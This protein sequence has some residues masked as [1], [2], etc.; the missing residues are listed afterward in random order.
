MKRK[1]K[2]RIAAGGVVFRKTGRRIR[3]ALI[4]RADWTVWCLPK[5]HL[6]PGETLEEGALREVREE[7]G[8]TAL[9]LR[10]LAPIHYRYREDRRVISKTVHFYLMRRTG[11]STQDHDFEVDEARWFD[12]REALKRLTHPAERRVLEKGLKRIQAGKGQ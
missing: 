8:L 2:R 7:T 9:I 11:G 10:K 12:S 6:D 1:G 5:G 3:I 4:A